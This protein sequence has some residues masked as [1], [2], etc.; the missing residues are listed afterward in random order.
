MQS[1]IESDEIIEKAPERYDGID[2]KVVTK[3]LGD[4]NPTVI[5]EYEAGNGAFS[6]KIAKILKNTKVY[7]CD[8]LDEN[9][10][11]MKALS[12]LEN[13]IPCQASALLLKQFVGFTDLFM[14]VDNFHTF[15]DPVSVLNIARRNLYSG[16]KVLIIDW[17]KQENPMNIPL[18]KLRTEWEYMQLLSDCK[19]AKI[20]S[21]ALFSD[22]LF[23]I[24]EK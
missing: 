1:Q 4:R 16:K 22:R 23:I 5:A 20:R 19:F 7:S 9:I 21:L 18:E 14:F 13:F 15:E 8:I 2:P 6:L 17:K 11:K 12:S 10:E 3:N 24:A